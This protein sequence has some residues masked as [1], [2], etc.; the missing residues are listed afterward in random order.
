MPVIVAMGGF[1]PTRPDFHSNPGGTRGVSP[2]P[3]VGPRTTPIPPPQPRQ[4][5]YFG[6]Y[7]GTLGYFPAQVP[8][9]TD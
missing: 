8:T 3:W 9:G 4:L 1:E 5:G 2:D 7:P 6:K